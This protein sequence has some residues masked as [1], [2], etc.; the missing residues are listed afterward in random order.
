MAGPDSGSSSIPSAAPFSYESGLPQPWDLSDILGPG[1]SGGS[2]EEAYSARDVRQWYVILQEDTRWFDRGARVAG[3][4]T[5]Q[6]PQHSLGSN[7]IEA[8]GYGRKNPVLMW[9]GGQI[10]TFSFEFLFS[11][12]ISFVL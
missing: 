12:A 9:V 4:F 8:G 2:D 6:Q 5:P 7:L 3:Q 1:Y 11:S 10:E